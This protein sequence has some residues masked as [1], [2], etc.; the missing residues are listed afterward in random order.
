MRTLYMNMSVVRTQ[1]EPSLV[2]NSNLFTNWTSGTP[3]VPYTH[4]L[5]ISPEMYVLPY[6][7]NVHMAKQAQGLIMHVPFKDTV[8]LP[9][10][11]RGMMFHCTSL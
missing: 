6:I 7:Q 1:S 8:Q 5:R 3:C 9:D 2:D 11:F 4:G 10:M